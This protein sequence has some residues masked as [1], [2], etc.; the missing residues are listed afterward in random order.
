MPAGDAAGE[1]GWHDG[2]D[3]RGVTPIAGVPAQDVEVLQSLQR[4]RRDDDCAARREPVNARE[5]R[6][7][8][9]EQ[10]AGQI[11]ARED[12]MPFDRARGDDDAQRMDEMEQVVG[13]DGDERALE[14]PDR[15][16]ALEDRRRCVAGQRVA[17][18]GDAIAQ[19]ARR[20]AL[21]DRPLV[22]E[23]HALASFRGG[24]RGRQP[25]DATPDDG[26]VRV[27]VHALLG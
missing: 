26:D 21:A 13:D 16:R 23:D 2:G 24:Q 25:G 20:N 7:A 6:R 14:D 18:C 10:H 9:T 11:V 17:Q 4:A 22:D 12:G 8:A 3:D 19:R 5:T 15:G 1:C 27:V